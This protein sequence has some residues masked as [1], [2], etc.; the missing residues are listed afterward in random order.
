MIHC[1]ISNSCVPPLRARRPTSWKNAAVIL[2]TLSRDLKCDAICASVSVASNR[3]TK[4]AELTISLPKPRINSSIPASTSEMYGIWLFGEYC[5]VTRLYGLS[6]VS[7][8][9]HSSCHAEY[10][11]L[12]PGSESR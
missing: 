10:S 2:S 11:I 8:F 1:C 4:F 12:L 9:C 5:M 3:A 6:I 7:R